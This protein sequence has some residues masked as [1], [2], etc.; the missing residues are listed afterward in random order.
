MKYVKFYDNSIIDALIDDDYG[1]KFGKK[2]IS[3][4]NLNQLENTDAEYVLFGIP[5]FSSGKDVNHSLDWFQLFLK[6]LLNIQNNQ[7]NRGE[8]LVVLGE[9]DAISIDKDLSDLKE[10]SEK[11]KKHKALIENIIFEISYAISQHGKIP[12]AIGGNHKNTFDLLKGISSSTLYAPN[13]LEL[14]TRVHL[15]SEENPQDLDFY[16]KAEILN[17]YH[18]FG[19]HSNHA[20]QKELDFI[21]S[22]KTAKYFLYEDCLHLT[23]LDKCVKFK[24]AVDFFNGSLGIALDLKSVQGLC[25]QRESSSGFS[26]RDLRT[27][28]KLARKE[29]VQ[30]FHICETETAQEKNI[31]NVLSYFV[32]DFVR[33][34]FLCSL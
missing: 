10:N 23:T 6:D 13:L 28:I 7:F 32:S 16:F 4:S 9:I 27:F 21:N 30:F 25:S 12:I 1:E 34:D 15:N 5:T 18:V 29:N 24:N 22:T 19:L 11:V 33:N 2:V 14:S 3:I 17:K 20:T 26:I 31:S 8:N